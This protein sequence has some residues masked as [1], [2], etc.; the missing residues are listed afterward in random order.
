MS[1]MKAEAERPPQVNTRKNRKRA[2][3]LNPDRSSIRARGL[4]VKR[5]RVPPR[6]HHP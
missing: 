2:H 5:C 4:S 1:E 3:W 6:C